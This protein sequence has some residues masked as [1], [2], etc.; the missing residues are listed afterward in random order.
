MSTATT[1]PPRQL[2]DLIKRLT[3]LGTK[4]ELDKSPDWFTVALAA[5][6]LQSLQIGVARIEP[7]PSI[8]DIVNAAR[9]SVMDRSPS[10][11]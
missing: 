10:H 4:L 5:A 3:N 11:A 1:I 7:M 9:H 8:T 6:M 2:D